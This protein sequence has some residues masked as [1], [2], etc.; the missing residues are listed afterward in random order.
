MRVG[1]S[2]HFGASG[3]SSKN[4]E[5]NLYTYAA[6]FL[7]ICTLIGVALID[8]EPD[9]RSDYETLN[10]TCPEPSFF[11][12]SDEVASSMTAK[13]SVGSW[14]ATIDLGVRDPDG[15][16]QASG[17]KFVVPCSFRVD[18]LGHDFYLLDSG[19][20]V[21][22]S[23]LAHTFTKGWSFEVYDCGAKLLASVEQQS[24]TRAGLE[25]DI[26]DSSGTLS[27]TTDY[28]LHRISGDKLLV[29]GSGD[30]QGTL[31]STITH[32]RSITGK[33][34]NI[35]MND[36]GEGDAGPGGD[37][38]VLAAIASYMTWKDMDGGK[39][40][41][42]GVC[43][44][45]IVPLELAIVLVVLA[46]SKVCVS[47]WRDHRARPSRTVNKHCT[48]S[49]GKAASDDRTIVRNPLRM[50]ELQRPLSNEL[51]QSDGIISPR[52]VDEV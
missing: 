14:E 50:S 44:Y 38:R 48:T 26:K 27:A 12:S 1:S 10:H 36:A 46:L 21:V 41:F 8:Q 20:E 49:K 18:R 39:G 3:R 22:A 32:D 11:R 16:F 29:H 13:R 6:C 33:E 34:W 7:V 9:V 35:V 17:F 25:L 52:V 45:F 15:D 31:L 30:Q 37:E 2:A 47:R 28:E 23:V 19:D 24:W 4:S 40:S 51:D 5:P 43:I 42:S